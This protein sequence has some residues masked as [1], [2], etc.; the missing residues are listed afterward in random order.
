MF[1][2]TLALRQQ[3]DPETALRLCE[4][5]L[6]GDPLRHPVH[7]LRGECLLALGRH[8]DAIENFSS[9]AERLTQN[10]KWAPARGQ[11]LAQ[12]GRVYRQL[13][14]L[15]LARDDLQA[16]QTLAPNAVWIQRELETVVNALSTPEQRVS[17]EHRSD[18]KGN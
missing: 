2:A 8:Q 18:I 6:A 15:E 1:A 11:T 10:P 5:S 4:H 13:G 14:Q 16:A 17:V 9:E 3:K 7:L 12:R